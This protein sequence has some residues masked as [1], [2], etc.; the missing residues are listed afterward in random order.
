[1]ATTTADLVQI[2]GITYA[3]DFAAHS[4]KWQV[5]TAQLPTVTSAAGNASSPP[6]LSTAV[7]AVATPAGVDL[8]DGTTGRVAR[9]VAMTS[10]PAGSS[11][12][13]LGSG[14]VLS[15]PSTEVYR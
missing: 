1:M 2:G 5:A 9:T 12:Y 13:P 3:I 10:V 15:G 6:D 14:F 7:V 8:L 11:A 4:P